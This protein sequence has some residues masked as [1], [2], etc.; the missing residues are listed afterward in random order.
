MAW[1]SREASLRE[2]E[3]KLG[4]SPAPS[5]ELAA[6]AQRPRTPGP[7]QRSPNPK[8]LGLSPAPSAEVA[9]G[10]QRPRTPGPPQRSANPKPDRARTPLAAAR[11]GSG[12]MGGAA[13]RAARAAEPRVSDPRTNPER[14]AGNA[15]ASGAAPGSGGGRLER[16]GSQGQGLGPRQ[17]S[18]PGQALGPRQGSGQGLE[19]RGSQGQSL[20]ALAR[21]VRAGLESGHAPQLEGLGREELDKLTSLLESMEREQAGA[22][23]ERCG[24]RV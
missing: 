18:A 17:G 14:H 9:A 24:P 11:A 15:A 4:L 2:L 8:P 7:P 3:A 20:A 22:G 21:S 23:G 13:A 10:A 19:R 12:D 6:G 5:A 1:Q 16:A